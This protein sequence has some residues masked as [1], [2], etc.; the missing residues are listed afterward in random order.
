MLI[1]GSVRSLAKYAQ[2]PAEALTRHQMH[3]G[4]PGVGSTPDT[5][6]R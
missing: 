6:P 1:A 2:V 3:V 5:F 4:V